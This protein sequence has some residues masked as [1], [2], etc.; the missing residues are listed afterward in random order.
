VFVGAYLG[1]PLFGETKTLLRFR[2]SGRRLV[3]A[4][5]R[6]KPAIANEQYG[7]TG[8]SAGALV[9]EKSSHR[10]TGCR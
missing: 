10:P 5:G 9:F 8:L 1:V 6:G 2:G 3:L 4:S 7:R